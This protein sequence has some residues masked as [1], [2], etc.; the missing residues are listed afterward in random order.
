MIIKLLAL[1]FYYGI[2]QHL[3]LNTRMT[4]NIGQK[5][6]V[7]ACRRIFKKTAKHFNVEKGAHFAQGGGIEI[8]ENSGIGI[9]CRLYGPVILG[10]DVMMGPEVVILT[11]N[12]KF[13]D[14][15]IPMWKQGYED[16]RPVII[17]D[18]VW[19]GTRVIILPGVTIGKGVII[20]AGA[21]VTKNVPDYAIVV[22]NPARIIKYRNGTNASSLSNKSEG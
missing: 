19:I 18:D 22:G 16:I 13:S 2:A 21:V 4:G 5:F 10:D 17:G 1:V 14:L 9:N 11:Q 15:N 6:R 8:G 12:H 3:P 7:F 20:G